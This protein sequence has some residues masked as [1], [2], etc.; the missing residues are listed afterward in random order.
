MSK[1]KSDEAGL[2]PAVPWLVRR[3][4]KWTTAFAN[5]RFEPARNEIIWLYRQTKSIDTVIAFARETSLFLD[6]VALFYTIA[7]RAPLT[8]Y[9]LLINALFE[10]IDHE[11]EEATVIALFDRMLAT[12]TSLSN[13]LCINLLIRILK[14]DDLLDR[15]IRI[16]RR[17]LLHMEEFKTWYWIVSAS[18]QGLIHQAIRTAL[19]GPAGARLFECLVADGYIETQLRQDFLRWRTNV[20]HLTDTCT[21]VL[22]KNRQASA[23]GIDYIGLYNS[24]SEMCPNAYKLGWPRHVSIGSFLDTVFWRRTAEVACALHELGLPVLQ[25]LEIIDA[26]LPNTYTM[27]AKWN[28]LAAAKHFHER[29]AL[30]M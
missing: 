1:R 21:Y 3:Q 4:Q 8:D 17:T 26:L 6:L 28:A 7:V 2:S 14:R 12:T 10:H 11:T 30:K 5:G 24:V 22:R 9:Y 16:V 18:D 20:P 29:R 13:D 19:C 27:H 25:T 15:Y 23:A